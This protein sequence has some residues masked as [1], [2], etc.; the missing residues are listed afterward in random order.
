MRSFWP[1]NAKPSA[2]LIFLHGYASHI[3]R[4][5]HR[6][7]SSSL[8]D[9]SIGYITLDFHAHGYSD[10]VRGLV[11]SVDDLID[12]VLSL[13][14]ALHDGSKESPNHKLTHD[15]VDIQSIPFYLMGHSMGGGTSLL[16]SN[17]LSKAGAKQSWTIQ[18]HS[19][20]HFENIS[21]VFRGC[22]LV[23]PLIQ[24]VE[25]H[26]AVRFLLGNV[27]ATLFP[28]VCMP[29]DDN[30]GNSKVWVHQSYIDYVVRDGFPANEKGLSWGGSIRFGTANTML[31]VSDRVVATIPEADFPFLIL[32]DPEDKVVRFE[33]S[34]RLFREAP[35]VDKT[36][37]VMEGALHDPIANQLS[38]V[39]SRVIAFVKQRS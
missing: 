7:L 27:L 26:V 23:C 3:N 20:S 37:V 11:S 2:V 22:I 24:I 29:G 31:A 25:L 4:P 5:I 33:G 38:A 28:Q 34:E 35:S 10:G 19:S 36:M 15:I 1:E 13:L 39:A 17:L 21:K 32:H 18:S 9:S 8:N 14:A 30:T 12:D 6:F 16:V